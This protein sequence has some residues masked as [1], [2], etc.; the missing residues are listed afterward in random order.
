MSEV[1][2]PERTAIAPAP[3][4]SWTPLGENAILVRS[5]CDAIPAKV[6]VAVDG[7]PRNRAQT[8]VLSWRRPGAEPSAATGFLC[9]APAPS[10]DD[11]G[12]GALL[13]GRPGRPLRLILAPKPQSLQAFLSERGGRPARS[14]AD[15]RAESAPSAGRGDAV[16]DGRAAGWFR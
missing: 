2:V 11:S 8:M 3:T 5:H 6:P 12:T 14:A 13:I 16:A 1:I 9:L 7:N 15:R 10:V 4:V